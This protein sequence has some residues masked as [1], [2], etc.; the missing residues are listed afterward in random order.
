MFLH[1]W[2]EVRHMSGQRKE[3][4]FV[5]VLLLAYFL[6]FL[7][8]P[9]IR[10]FVQS[11]DTG[12][13]LSFSAYKDVFTDTEFARGMRN[14]VCI[15]LISALIS[16]AISFLLAYTVHFTNLSDSIKRIIRV[17]A[18]MPML[19]PTITYGFALIYSFGKNGFLTRLFGY[20]IL[21]VYGQTGMII[22]FVIYTIPTSFV[23]LDNTMQYIDRR[24][25]LVSRLMK[26]RPARGFLNTICVPMTGTVLTAL[27]E[28]FTLSFTDYGIPTSIAGNM[29]VMATILYTSML[30]SL[31]DF[32]KGSVIAVYMLAPSVVSVILVWRLRKFNV[33]YSDVQDEPLAG[34]RLR[35]FLCGIVSFAVLAS[36]ILIFASVFIIPFIEQWP[37]KIH[38]TF[39]HFATVFSDPNMGMIIKNSLILAFFTSLFGTLAVYFGALLSGRGYRPRFP[40]KIMDITALVINTIPGMVLGVAYLMT[41]RGTRLHNS[42]AILVICTVVHLFPTPFLMMKNALEKLNLQ[43]ETTA[44]LM[45][46]SWLKTVIRVIT[47]NALSSLLESFSYY[48]VNTMV[49]ISAVI[50]LVSARTTLITTKIK[51]LQHFQDFD[52]IFVLSILIFAINL[53]VKIMI[54]I[55][56]SHADDLKQG[57]KGK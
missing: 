24:Y 44:A 11:V 37:Y 1:I 4:T 54:N 14:S 56:K 21:D 34:N 36:I 13:G 8:A 33:R 9:V 51:E 39:S 29:N 57:G 35:D 7:G 20:Q 16:T 12:T 30:G 3:I 26:D 25:I 52:D 23:L 10:I 49:T 55:L 50:F 40:G 38:F 28:S 31:P 18:V 6:L 41:F 2:K 19:I 45:R 27:I 17:F 5:F 47:P 43:W 53:A 42:F 15:S 22:G 32:T 48:F 46:D